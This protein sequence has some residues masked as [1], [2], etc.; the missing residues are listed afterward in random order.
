MFD[1]NSHTVFKDEEDEISSKKNGRGKRHVDTTKNNQISY[2][3]SS[4]V[5]ATNAR[6]RI[7]GLWHK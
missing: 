7:K 6:C 3:D 1:R 2:S 5:E 4:Q